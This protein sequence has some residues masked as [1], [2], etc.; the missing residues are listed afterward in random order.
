MVRVIKVHPQDNVVIP[1][2]DAPRGTEVAPEVKTIQDIPQG[3]K[4]ALKDFRKGDEVMR[5]GVILGSLLKDVPAGGHIDET[6][7]EMPPPPG[8]DEMPW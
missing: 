3:H 5:Y 8:L 6:M 4:I 7:L 1:V 2:Q